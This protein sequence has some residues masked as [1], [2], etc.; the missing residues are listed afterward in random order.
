MKSLYGFERKYADSASELYSALTDL[1]HPS[2]KEYQRHVRIWNFR[3]GL[4]Q[5]EWRFVGRR[6]AKRKAEEGKESEL[7][8]N[9]HPFPQRKIRKALSRN[10]ETTYENLQRQSVIRRSHT[11]EGFM[12]R[13]PRQRSPAACVYRENF[14]IISVDRLLPSCPAMVALMILIMELHGEYTNQFSR[15]GGRFSKKVWLILK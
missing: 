9:S 6:I 1:T 8:V 5:E 7:I 12:I 11:P 10:F 4:K 14:I 15:A 13:T 2:M 3:K